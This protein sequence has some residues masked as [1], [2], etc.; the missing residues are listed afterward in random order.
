MPYRHEVA[1]ILFGLS[2]A[3]ETPI[4]IWGSINQ[5]HT[6]HYK[7]NNDCLECQ[8]LNFMFTENAPPCQ[9][10]VENNNITWMDAATGNTSLNFVLIYIN[11][12]SQMGYRTP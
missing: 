10:W 11:T 1:V 5:R 6:H 8:N 2:G 7:T 9:S 3:L 12:T 4:T